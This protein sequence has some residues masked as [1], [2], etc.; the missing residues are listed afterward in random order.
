MSN[1]EVEKIEVVEMRPKSIVEVVNGTLLPLKREEVPYGNVQDG[2][3]KD[4]VSEIR[5]YYHSDEAIRMVIDDFESFL[6]IKSEVYRAYKD[7]TVSL[8]QHLIA[9]TQFMWEST[10]GHSDDDSMFLKG[11]EISDVINRKTRP[12]TRCNIFNMAY[13]DLFFA[14]DNRFSLGFS[15]KVALVFSHA[16]I[17]KDYGAIYIISDYRPARSIRKVPHV[18]LSMVTKDQNGLAY[19]MIDP[20]HTK[21]G[22]TE[23]RALDFTDLRS[24]NFIYNLVRSVPKFI[25]AM[26]FVNKVKSELTQFSSLA[27]AYFLVDIFFKGDFERDDYDDRAIIKYNMESI[28][29]IDKSILEDPNHDVTP[30][31]IEE[32]NRERDEKVARVN[33]RNEVH[34]AIAQYAFDAI[35]EG[36]KKI[37]VGEKVFENITYLSSLFDLLVIKGVDLPDGLMKG[38]N[39]VLKRISTNRRKLLSRFTPEERELIGRRVR[40]DELYIPPNLSD[41]DLSEWVGIKQSLLKMAKSSQA[42]NPDRKYIEFKSK[43]EESKDPKAKVLLKLMWGE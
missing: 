1:A 41:K 32:L 23:L 20:Y 30:G 9:L 13:A 42:I 24:D 8:E 3:D 39:N 38:I 10:D 37:E 15:E 7:R 29:R 33:K 27:R 40:T 34:N 16:E 35:S 4:P 5:P 2:G 19:T 21:P 28:N 22:I 12:K 6:R 25:E 14:I 31:R 36:V 17:V 26:G 18:F 43:L 11:G